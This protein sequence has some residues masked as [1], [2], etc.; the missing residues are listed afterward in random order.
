MKE[1]AAATA[2][3][4]R[5]HRG[6][7]PEF[8]TDLDAQWAVGDKLHGG[9]L[10]AILG[11]AAGLV[12]TGHP[13]L[14]AVSGAFVRAPRP[15]PAVVVVETLRAGRSSTQLRARLVQDS[16]PRVEAL[17][18]Q[19]TLTEGDPWWSGAPSVTLP[20]EEECVPT[21]H[22]A[23]AFRVPL[24]EVVDQR[25]DPAT[26]GF[27]TGAPSHAG[28]VA[29]WQRLADGTG[30]DPLSLLVA[31]DQVPPPT[32]DLGLP[33]WVPTIQ[34]TAYIR[35]LPAPGPVSVRLVANQVTADRID[36]T[37]HAWDSKGRLVA[38]ATQYAAVRT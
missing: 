37:A 34:L 30:W 12:S 32:F 10:L 4:P 1:F 3:R 38:Q 17:I 13:H 33:G 29:G 21:S 23:G 14:T 35:H 5:P 6:A 9:Y 36:E 16:E 22:E 20:P 11:R 27:A 8:D 7:Q 18:T 31:L 24:M 28:R 15:G 25:L 26:L 2:V 19:G